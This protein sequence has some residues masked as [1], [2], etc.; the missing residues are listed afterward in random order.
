ME[1]SVEHTLYLVDRNRLDLTGV[2]DVDSFNEEE[3]DAICDFGELI[4]KGDLLHIE[5]LNLDDGTLS[6]TGKIVTM[7]YNEKLN[8]ASVFKRLFGG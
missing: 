5:Q 1:N 3:I 4:I 8:S 6:I 7:Q 2:K